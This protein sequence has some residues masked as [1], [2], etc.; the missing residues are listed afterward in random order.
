M[1]SEQN[2]NLN[3]NVCFTKI[4]VTEAAD[5]TA[6]IASA[7]I[8]S[9]KSSIYL[10]VWFQYNGDLLEVTSKNGNVAT[11]SYVEETNLDTVNLSVDLVENLVKMFGK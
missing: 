3:C 4:T 1:Y 6:K 11:C 10:G 9:A 2:R 7:N 8:V 5:A